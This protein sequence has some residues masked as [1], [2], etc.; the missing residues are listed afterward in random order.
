MGLLAMSEVVP[1]FMRGTQRTSLQ[2][3]PLEKSTHKN[4]QPLDTR[5]H[6]E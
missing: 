1:E 4:L 6:L 3:N 2:S 5:C